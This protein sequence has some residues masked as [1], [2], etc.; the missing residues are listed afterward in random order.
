MGGTNNKPENPATLAEQGNQPYTTPPADGPS[1]KAKDRN[2]IGIIGLVCAVLGTILSCIP[3]ILL[4]GWILLPI[5]FILGLVG[6]F[7]KD[8]AKGTAI[9]AVIISIVGTIVAAVVFA[10]VVDSAIDDTFNKETTVSNNSDNSNDASDQPANQASDAADGSTRENPLPIGSTI[11]SDEWEVTINSVDLDATDAILAENEFNEVPADGQTYVLANVTAKYT[12]DDPQGSS[13][14]VSVA[15]VSPQGNTVQSFDAPVITPD[16]FDLGN[17]LYK[18]ASTTG[19][20][21]FLVDKAT[22]NEGV[23]SVEPD[24]FS[25]KRFVS[26]N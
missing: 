3:G 26:V 1:P 7:P 19:N 15:Y 23:L 10:F 22:A 13:P 11:S 16:A 8:K 5:A 20:L 14:W 2:V 21:V 17:T 4:A 9:A 12:G 25:R 18:D 6:L 24:P